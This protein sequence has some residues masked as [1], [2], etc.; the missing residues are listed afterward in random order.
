MAPSDIMTLVVP[1]DYD[2]LLDGSITDH[3]QLHDHL[4]GFTENLDNDI[5]DYLKQHDINH[6]WHQV[7]S[8]E[9]QNKYPGCRF[10]ADTQHQLNFRHFY[11][12]RMH[13]DNNITKF[14]CSFNGE[15]H[16]GRQLLVSILHKFGWFNADTCTKLF[17]IHKD[18]IDGYIKSA[19]YNKFFSFDSSFLNTRYELGGHENYRFTHNKNIMELQKP[20]TE[21]FVHVVSE[22]MSQSHYPFVT[23]KFLYSIITRGL[24]VA[25]A[26]PGWH[27]HIKDY[28]GF[29]LYDRIFD[30]SFDS[31]VD[32]VERLVKLIEMLH[33][34]SILSTDDWT[35][36]YEME[37]DTINYNYDHYHSKAYV[38]L[39]KKFDTT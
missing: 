21:S 17:V 1:K 14:V 33:K 23:E 12:Y 28:Y 6:E 9:L 8:P 20:L 34:F 18:K 25:Y 26:Q 38:P 30:Y 13:P 37:V 2:R 27:A 39:L 24:F 3:V 11:D 10:N 35:N 15:P 36:L 4:N 19:L 22:T 5:L 31:V 29:K 32:T 7:L 16:V